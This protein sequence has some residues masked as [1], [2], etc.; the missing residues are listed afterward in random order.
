[1]MYMNSFYDFS[2]VTVYPTVFVI[3]ENISIN[4]YKR[5]YFLQILNVCV[6]QLKSSPAVSFRNLSQ[7]PNTLIVFRKYS[8]LLDLPLSKKALKVHLLFAAIVCA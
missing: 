2:L 8:Q 1:M 3:M 7:C 6:F 5:L 4:H